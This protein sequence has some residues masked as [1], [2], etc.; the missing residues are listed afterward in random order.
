M[1]ETPFTF[2]VYDKNFAF[3][4][5]IGD[6]ISLAVTPRFNQVGTGVLVVETDHP[7]VPYLMADGARFV[8]ELRGAFLMSGKI[9]RREAAGPAVDG[10]LTVYLKDDFRLLQQVLGYPVP[11]SPLSSQGGS[12]FAKYTGNAETIVKTAVQNNMVA[13]LG[14]PV[15]VSANQ[16]RG[17]TIPDG[18][19]LRFHPLYEKLF[20][21]VETAGLGVTF[22]Q[23]GAGITCDVFTPQPF[24]QI[25]TED[26]G[27]LQAW[28]WASED[29]LATHVVAGGKGDGTA[30]T[31]RDARSSSLEAA[32]HDV[33]E[34]F[35]DATD[36]DTT[37]IL[38]SRAQAALEENS[39]KSGFSV[40][41]S[42][43]EH[44]Q[45]GVDGLVVGALVTIGI[46]FVTR[47]DYLREVTLNYT[48]DEGLVTIP[49]VGEI[50]DS[51]DR[52]IAQFL[53]RLKKGLNDLKV[54]K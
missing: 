29:P 12:E 25:L 20:P 39:S 8:V 48:R 50:N 7:S 33:I 42:E 44:F 43:T 3:K 30:R 17:A 53:A 36:A 54:S 15:T 46:G 18:V 16:N 2:K 35:T 24:G 32:H 14:M 28:S 49:V 11:D 31:F 6:P 37:T 27:V 40:Q 47:T 22:Q 52:T 51:P 34:L 26:S 4:A 41:L 1:A 10:T 5:F 23:S 38:T 13:R 9:T 19:S 21:A 45:Y